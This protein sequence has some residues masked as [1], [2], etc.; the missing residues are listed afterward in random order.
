VTGQAPGIGH[1]G[2]ASMRA[3]AQEIGW[4]LV[5]TSAPGSG[6]CVRVEQAR[7]EGQR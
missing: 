1:L 2:L 6:T 5:V 3:R 7:Q 4:R